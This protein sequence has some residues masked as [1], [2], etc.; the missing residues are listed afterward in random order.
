MTAMTTQG[1]SGGVRARKANP[2]WIGDYV[3]RLD[4]EEAEVKTGATA[5]GK[6]MRQVYH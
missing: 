5:M 2:Q 1:G 3:T 6:A 4:L